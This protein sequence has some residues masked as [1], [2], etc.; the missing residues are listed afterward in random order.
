MPRPNAINQSLYPYHVGGR[1]INRE[2]FSLRIDHVWEIF[3]TQL[4]FAHHRYGALIH[5]C[6][7]MSNHY[8]LLISTPEGNLSEVMQNFSRETSRWLNLEAGRINQSYGGRHYRSIIQCD[9]YFR[10]AYKYVY[11]NPVKAGLCER[12]EDYPF[13]TLHGL[14]GQQRLFIPLAEDRILMPDI[15]KTLVWLN[16]APSDENWRVVGRA[17]HRSR[18]W[19]PKNRDTKK[20]HVLE[21]DAL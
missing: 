14:L 2:R 12:V 17:L 21:F 13:S 10:H 20:D 18:F 11:R 9:H 8:H 3:E 1:S 6:V 15:E 7:L 5:A 4:Y 19:L 16:Q